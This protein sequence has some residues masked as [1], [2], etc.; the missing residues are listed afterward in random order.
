MEWSGWIHSNR[1]FANKTVCNHRYEWRLYGNR[2][3]WRMHYDCNNNGN[4]KSCAGSNCI[5][6]WS[7]LR[8]SNNSV[9]RHRWGNL[10]M[11]RTGRIYCNRCFANKTYCYNRHERCLYRYCNN[12][13]LY[14]HSDNECHSKSC[15]N[16]HGK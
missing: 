8:G 2:Y 7:V 10:F 4:G 14:S 12:K 3:K 11:E 6:W 1:S 15:T 13:W 5:Q 16:T 9:K